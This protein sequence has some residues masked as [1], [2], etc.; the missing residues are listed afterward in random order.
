MKASFCNFPLSL[1]QP[2]A[3]ILLSIPH[4]GFSE[5]IIIMME[6]IKKKYSKNIHLVLSVSLYLFF[7]FVEKMRAG[8]PVIRPRG[9]P[10][11][12]ERPGTAPVS[13]VTHFCAPIKRREKP[14]KEC[15]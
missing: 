5:T 7:F 12:R 8:K 15:K 6:V 11:R 14:G 3:Y 10:S 13:P 1:A 2:T 9:W 4:G